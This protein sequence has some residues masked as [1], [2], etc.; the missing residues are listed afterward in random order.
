MGRR[1]GSPQTWQEARRKR[2]LELNQFQWKQ[3]EIAEALGVS[4][5][6]VS[7][8]LAITRE[9]GMEW[10]IHGPQTPPE[11]MNREPQ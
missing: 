4:P 8:R 11:E 3:C 6:A 1:T 2:A 9:H 7:Q 5:A 10:M